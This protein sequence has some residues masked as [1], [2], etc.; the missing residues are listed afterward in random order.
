M[1]G[2]RFVGWLRAQ[3]EEVVGWD[4]P[5][6]DITDVKK[7]I[8]GIHKVGPDVVFHF[9]AWTDVD[10]CEGNP[11]K[12]TST[13][14]QGT[15]VVAL[16][17]AE[18]GCRLLHVSTDYVFDGRTGRPYHERDKPNPLSVYGRS[19]LMAEKAVTKSCSRRYIVRISGL[20]GRYGRNFV[21]T[22]R[23]LAAK[24]K[25]LEVVADQ[26]SSPT[27]ARDLCEP[28]LELA[29]SREYGTYHL[30]NSGQCS[31][32]E[33]AREVVS[34][35]GAGCQVL[36]ISTDKAGRPASRPAF[37]VLE[38]RNFKKKFGKVLRPWQ[39]ALKEYLLEG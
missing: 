21:D 25:R 4:L 39:D 30:T 17:A 36:P 29:R 15:W 14:F 22:I 12:A 1:L 24:K 5:G 13:N 27:Y 2:T 6:H 11:G 9:A 16:G 8:N 3:G 31:W 32:Y 37:S 7:T 23:T 19:K 33:L 10:G 26:V 35:V 38:N 18:L 20:F 28:L 34:L